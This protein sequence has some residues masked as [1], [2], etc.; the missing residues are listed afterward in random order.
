MYQ[1]PKEG[2]WG[3]LVSEGSLIGR[4]GHEDEVR[5]DMQLHRTQLENYMLKTYKPGQE[6]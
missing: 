6:Y 4:E 1:F 3:I 2:R 5:K